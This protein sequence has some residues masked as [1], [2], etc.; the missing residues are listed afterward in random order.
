MVNQRLSEHL[1]AYYEGE[2]LPSEKLTHLLDMAETVRD[3]GRKEHTPRKKMILSSVRPPRRFTSVLL[4][5][6]AAMMVLFF[7]QPSSDVRQRVAKE[8]VLNH[9][10]GLSV[11]FSSEDYADLRRKMSKL[12][13]ALV[14][15][16]RIDPERFRVFGGRYCSIQGELAA[17]IKFQ[18]ETGR[19]YTLYQTALTG[20]LKNLKTG[21]LQQDGLQLTLWQ[22]AGLFFAFVGPADGVF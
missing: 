2:S 9:N 20:D 4:L 1:H 14:N 17:Q 11:E 13:F 5:A 21:T 18:D 6:L 10:K 7:F 22:E 19:I 8:A 16:K 15:P 12:D 3:E